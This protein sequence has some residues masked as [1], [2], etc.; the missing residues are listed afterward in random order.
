MATSQKLQYRILKQKMK[1]MKNLISENIASDTNKL[2]MSEESEYVGKRN[3]SK[4]ELQNR[5]SQEQEDIRKLRIKQFDARKYL[6]KN[7]ESIKKIPI[8][9]NGKSNFSKMYLYFHRKRL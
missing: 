6:Q 2:S 5:F 7:E 8:F 9:S 1:Q 3:I 4:D